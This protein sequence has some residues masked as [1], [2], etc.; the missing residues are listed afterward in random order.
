[1]TNFPAL[2]CASHIWSVTKNS[3]GRSYDAQVRR[4]QLYFFDTWWLRSQCAKIGTKDI[5]RGILQI[6]RWSQGYPIYRINEASF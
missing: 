2:E 3:R 5:G 6:L 4:L 1:L